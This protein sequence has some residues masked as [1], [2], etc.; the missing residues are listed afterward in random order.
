MAYQT[1]LLEQEKFDYD[2]FL[3]KVELIESN[4]KDDV[5]NY[6]RGR[7]IYVLLN[8]LFDA[9]Y[10]VKTTVSDIHEVMGDIKFDVLV[11]P[12][13]FSNCVLYS[14]REPGRKSFRGKIRYTPPNTLA[15]TVRWITRDNKSMK[16]R[17]AGFDN[18]PILQDEKFL[19][20]ECDRLYKNNEIG[21]DYDYIERH[22]FRFLTDDKR[23]A[24]GEDYVRRNQEAALNDSQMVHR[25]LCQYF[26]VTNS[27]GICYEYA[28]NCFIFPMKREYI[29]EIFKKRDKENGRRR[30]IASLVKGYTRNDGTEVDGHLRTHDGFS[31]GGRD[32]S[33]LIGAEDFGKMFPNSEK[34]K[35]R[36]KNIINTSEFDG[37]FLAVRRHVR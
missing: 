35:K 37:D 30:V 13:G 23:I 19:V 5:L 28:G 2:F 3:S 27:W 31:I 11:N 22:A 10:F 9:T 8:G 33:L 26:D 21:A 34:S 15:L 18:M 4:F 1:D 24:C 16:M 12:D 29:Q 32:F 20:S 14:I 6:I 17:C 7:H 25:A 36:I